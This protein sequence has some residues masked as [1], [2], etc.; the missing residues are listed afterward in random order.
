MSDL[1][2]ILLVED[3]ADDFEATLRSLKKNHLV[4][5]VAWCRNGEDALDYL[6]RAGA[7]ADGKNITR[8]AL[9]LLDLNMP[10]M[11]GRRVL[12]IIKSEEELRS[13]PVVILTTS[14]DSKDVDQCYAIGANTYIQ[15]PVSFEGLTQAIAAMKDYWFGIALLP[16]RAE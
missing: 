12:E 9:I 8:P 6:H 2:H 7:Y 11:D 14:S 3:N 13:I 10:G 5:P 1:A 16:V 4:N 15:K